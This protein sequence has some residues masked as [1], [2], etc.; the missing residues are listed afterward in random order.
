MPATTHQRLAALLGGIVRSDEVS[1]ALWAT[2]ASIY[3]RRPVAV[4][5]PRSERELRKV[6]GACRAVGVPLTARGGGTSLAGQATSD[7]LVMDVSHYHECLKLDTQQKSC[8]VQPGMVQAELNRLAAS[9]GLIFG[10]DTSTSEVATLGGMIG[11][12]SA[13]MRSV[14]YGT[15]ADQVLELR[16]I[17]TRAEVFTLRPLARA[18]AVELARGDSWLA[19][20]YRTCL[21][22]GERY[23]SVIEHSYPHMIRRVSG[24]D[25]ST[26]I[27]P[28][29]VDL[30]RLICASEGTLAV[31]S[32]AELK[33]HPL[34]EHRQLVSL[35]FDS[36]QA[37]CRANLEI[38]KLDPSAVEL[39]DGIAI[40]RAR[41]NPTYAPT[42]SFLAGDPQAVLLCEWSGSRDE[43]AERVAEAIRLMREQN[44]LIAPPRVLDADEYQATIQ[45]RKAIL[46]LLLG[47]LDAAK[48][49]AFVED[50]A[51]PPEQ[52]ETFIARFQNILTSYDTW[53]CF[54]G[55][56]SVGCLH[57]RPAIDTR[58][59]AG[60][61]NMREIA[62]EVAD[63]VVELGGTVSG[64]HG[65]GLSRSEFI[66]K[67]YPDLIPAFE[68]IK[69]AFDPDGLLNPGIITQPLAM[70]TNLRQDPEYSPR[71]L[72]THL[73]FSR[74]GGL[75][76]AAALCN[77]S[78]FCRKH[79][80]GTMCPSYMVTRDERDS[81]RARANMLRSVMD[82]SLPIEHMASPQMKEVMDL[83]VGCKACASECPSQVD[84]ASM[85]I[86]VLAQIAER[87]GYT[88]QQYLAGFARYG[89]A[90]ASRTP[91]LAN[92][93]NGSRAARRLASLAG[94]DHRRHLPLVSRHRF[95]SRF[96]NTEG[97]Q[98]V[99][100][101]SDTWTEYQRPDIGA[102]AVRV[103]AAGNARVRMPKAVCCGRTMLSE[104][105]VDAARWH[106]KKNL[107][108]LDEVIRKEIPLVGIEP[109][110][111]LTIRDDYQRLLPDDDRVPRLAALTRTFEEMLL[112]LDPIEF[113]PGPPVTVHGHCHQKALVGTK[114]MQTVLERAS[115]QVTMLDS[116]CCGM[117]GSFGYQAEHY[118]VSMQ[119]GER[120]L[121]PAART[122]GVVIA[123][124]VSCRE[125]IADGTGQKALHPAE[126][127]ASYLPG[128][129]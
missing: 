87:E 116:G 104:G 27:D 31:V 47:T 92:T 34:P 37:A 29:Q 79:T 53:G 126:Y 17:N 73:D 71:T 100:L 7:G 49:I 56:A 112:E 59:R 22:I 81:T 18:D 93:I 89:L 28:E 15:T 127:L 115:D 5:T 111:I 44:G 122:A 106:A 30:T 36:L 2:D 67:M 21:D 19:G 20:L 98:A 76:Q 129:S 41:S 26:L 124:G 101:F 54:Y 51:V 109:S 57:V 13:G 11:N 86:E 125:Q 33:L 96:E 39:L 40:A 91:R 25:L 14:Q 117:A 16:C 64:E 42:T 99:A 121:F 65:D 107:D 58:S 23:R 52:L 110:C 32:E 113:A 10:A 74:Q 108:L 69:A 9:E 90:A 77:G 66:Q 94:I 55:H 114:P 85:K 6:I 50:A 62:T 120:V 46:P 3:H 95:S 84:V 38:L 35:E 45:L 68:E 118:E 82:G 80:G 83:C 60:V 105:L 12:N 88:L 103:L 43:V 4:A 119:M 97:A 61:D 123:P 24:Y 78:G 1:T 72:P 8:R 102:C 75:A 63:L 70:D 128:L 48:P